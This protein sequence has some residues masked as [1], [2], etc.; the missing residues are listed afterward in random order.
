M[1]STYSDRISGVETALAIKAPVKVA[2][3]ANIT[4]SGTQTIDGV[5]VVA[6]DRVLVK[7]QTDA[8]KN[9][10]YVAAAAAWSRA[11]DFNGSRDVAQG[12]AVYVAQGTANAGLR[13]TQTT[14]DPVIGTTNLTFSTTTGASAV[15]SS[16]LQGDDWTL[17]GTWDFT[18]ATLLLPDDAVTI[19]KIADAVLS[20]Q[21]AKLITGTPGSNGKLAQWNNDGDL[22][23]GPGK[24]GQ[25]AN[26]VTGTAGTD[27]NLPHWNADGDLVDSGVA[28]SA[29]S[30]PI[31]AGGQLDGTGTPAWH[32]RNNFSATV[33][34]NGTGN[35]SITFDTAEANANYLVLFGVGDDTG[36][37]RHF[38]Y[39]KNKATTG[40][41]I[42]IENIN[43]AAIDLQFLDIIVIRLP[44][45]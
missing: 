4:L 5:A 20:G 11:T 37:A 25:D 7:N 42:V 23:G 30:S 39:S 3:T 22:V 35:Y 45:S 26:V 13:Y 9:G 44:W 34:D 31:I 1:T 17:T 14:A 32:Y 10:I 18:A 33:T 8:T 43:G 36:D 28:S 27:G 24:T 19:A 29:V 38:V 21:D 2:T 6:G 12:T 41:D 16:E 15:T 40:F